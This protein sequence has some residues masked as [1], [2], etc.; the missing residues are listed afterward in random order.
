MIN[1]HQIIPEELLLLSYA[2]D[3]VLLGKGS[4]MRKL[5][6]IL[7][8]TLGEINTWLMEHDLSL[9]LPKCEAVWF[10]KSHNLLQPPPII[11]E[12]YTLIYVNEVKH[13]GVIINHNLR[14]D[15]HIEQMC[16]K[17]RKGINILKTFC[18]VWWGADPLSLWLAF[19]GIVR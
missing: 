6:T 4:N 1:L 16:N 18:G 5:T 10:T 2:D 12:N 17:A 15:N 14:W 11:I 9:A 13:L 8:R 3:L 7:N 19:N